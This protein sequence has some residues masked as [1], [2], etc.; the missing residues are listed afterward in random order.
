MRSTVCQLL[1]VSAADV[2]PVHARV[3]VPAG[4]LVGL[5]Q[6]LKD[7]PRRAAL[8]PA[9]TELELKP[10]AVGPDVDI[11]PTQPAVIAIPPV[12]DDRAIHVRDRTHVRSATCAKQDTRTSA[13]PPRRASP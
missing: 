9:F 6:F 5:P 8:R 10:A 11:A 12:P 13:E 7:G 1:L 3:A 2:A 4:F